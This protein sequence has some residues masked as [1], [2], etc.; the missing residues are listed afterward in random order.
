VIFLATW[1][2]TNYTDYCMNSQQEQLSNPPVEDAVFLADE[3][4]KKLQ[5]I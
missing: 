4:W 3:A 2:A 1:A 5:S